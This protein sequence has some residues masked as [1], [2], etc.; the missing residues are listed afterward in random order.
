MSLINEILVLASRNKGKIIE[1]EALLNPLGFQVKSL[2]DFPQ[3]GEID[4]TG[5]TFE[6]NALLKAR[7][8][9]KVTGGYVLADDSGLE[10]D[11]LQGQPGIYSARFAKKGATDEENNK[12]LIESLSE[13][14]DPSRKARYVCVLVLMTPAGDEHVVRE[15]CEGMITLIPGG[16]GGF[17]YDPYFYVPELKATMAEIPLEKKNK[18]SHRGKAL[19]S[20]IDLIQNK[21]LKQ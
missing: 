14:H 16:S 3:I 15:T 5:T 6:E 8:V 1:M 21:L 9:H 12:K 13:I 11:D 2:K 7:S 17:G 10:C 18:I 19:C 20:L 4:E